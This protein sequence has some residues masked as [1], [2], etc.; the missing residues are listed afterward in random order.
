MHRKWSL[1]DVK[2]EQ[3]QSVL[4]PTVKAI[5]K[6]WFCDYCATVSHSV[7]YTDCMACGRKTEEVK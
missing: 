4:P 6:R 7:N 5:F 1:E 2:K 3:A